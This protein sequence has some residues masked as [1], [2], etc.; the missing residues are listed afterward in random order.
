MYDWIVIII[1]LY[2]FNISTYTICVH[3][4]SLCRD[5][6][7]GIDS[8]FDYAFHARCICLLDICNAWSLCVVVAISNGLGCIYP[9]LWWSI[10]CF[11]WERVLTNDQIMLCHNVRFNRHLREHYLE[12][13]DYVPVWYLEKNSIIFC[14]SFSFNILTM[15]NTFYF[16]TKIKAPKLLMQNLLKFIF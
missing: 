1:N 15:G 2:K 5:F 13:C 14:N 7:E 3:F 8:L 9:L 16:I 10:A 12:L 11:S 6:I 4:N